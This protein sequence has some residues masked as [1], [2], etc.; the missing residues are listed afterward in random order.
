MTII[1]NAKRMATGLLLL[2]SISAARG[3]PAI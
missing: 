3:S 1:A 2:D